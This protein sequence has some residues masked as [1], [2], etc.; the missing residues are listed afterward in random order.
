MKRVLISTALGVLTACGLPAVAQ[1]ARQNTEPDSRSKRADQSEAQADDAANKSAKPAQSDQLRTGQALV[2][3]ARAEQSDTEQRAI[4]GVRA[5]QSRTIGVHVAAIDT[6]GPAGTAGLLADDYILDVDGKAIS[7][8][9]ELSQAIAMKKPGES[10]KLQIWRDGE[11]RTLDVALGAEWPADHRGGNQ[12]SNDDDRASDPDAWLGVLLGMTDDGQGIRIERILPGSP[13]DKSG[14]RRGDILKQLDGEAIASVGAFIRD[15]DKAKPQQKITLQIQRG[16]KVM[17][18]DVV[19]E[20][21]SGFDFESGFRSVD[22]SA[23]ESE[24]E[25]SDIFDTDRPAS[26][27]FLLDQHRRLA[28]QNQRLEMMLIDIRRELQDMRR[29]MKS[30]ARN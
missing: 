1:D 23:D 9:R 15:I 26:R 20:E 5:A 3:Q 30:D 12:R 19:L 25:W 22:D 24:E 6:F 27:D 10:V 4:L 16:D 7:S 21:A 28:E 29:E 17:P 13:A 8:P 11:R 14:L 2:G 18:K